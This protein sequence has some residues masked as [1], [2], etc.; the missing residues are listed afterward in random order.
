VVNVDR[1][2]G[3]KGARLGSLRF[4]RARRSHQYHN[5]EIG[6]QPVTTVKHSG[7]CMTSRSTGMAMVAGIARTGPV[8]ILRIPDGSTGWH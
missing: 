6:S 4:E 3:V 7:V 2:E 5:E 8:S 1:V